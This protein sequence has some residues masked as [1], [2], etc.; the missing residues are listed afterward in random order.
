MKI[1]LDQFKNF[2]TKLRVIEIL[3]KMTNFAICLTAYTTV[4]VKPTDKSEPTLPSVKLVSLTE[5]RVRQHLEF[6]FTKNT[7]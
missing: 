5:G 1:R 3:P 2:N 7:K 6:R 4:L